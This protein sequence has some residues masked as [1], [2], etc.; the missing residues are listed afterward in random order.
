M[1][2]DEISVTKRANMSTCSQAELEQCCI[3]GSLVITVYNDL[4][5]RLD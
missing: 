3:V 5:F 4:E 2:T 1:H